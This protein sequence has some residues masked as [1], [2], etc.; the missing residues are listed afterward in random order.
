MV[1]IAVIMTKTKV[2]RTVVISAQSCVASVANQPFIFTKTIFGISR[3]VFKRTFAKSGPNFL[4]ISFLCT[5][6]VLRFWPIT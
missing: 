6:V 1:A 4:L 5:R 2:V 3:F